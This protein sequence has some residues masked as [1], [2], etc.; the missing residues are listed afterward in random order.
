MQKK[1]STPEAVVQSVSQPQSK[2]VSPLRARMLA[3]MTERKFVHGTQAAYVRAIVG[4]V[5]HCD[6]RRP[7]AIPVSEARAYL[8]RYIFRV[9]L[10]DSAILRADDREVV[11]RYRDSDT[12]QP[13]TARLAPQEFMRRFLLHVLPAGFC[14]VRHYG[15]HHSSKRK[16]LRL[17]QAQ[18]AFTRQLPMPLADPPKLPPAP[19]PTCPHCQA[20]MLPETRLQPTRLR[21]SAQASA[22]G[23]P[24]P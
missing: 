20:A 13:R 14:K 19:P 24:A 21:G 1:R 17:L 16:T 12:G 23:P 3:A 2:P 8:A 4:L 9:A 11:F 22:R 10:A 15:L 6:G 5:R 7:E 18:L